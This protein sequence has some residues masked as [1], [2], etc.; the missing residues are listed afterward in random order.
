LNT[1]ELSNQYSK[2]P[3]F[4]DS[5]SAS[6]KKQKIL[7]RH[8]APWN[9]QKVQVLSE[10]MWSNKVHNLWNRESRILK[11]FCKMK[12]TNW[13]TWMNSKKPTESL[14]WKEIALSHSTNLRLISLNLS[15]VIVPHKQWRN[16]DQKKQRLQMLP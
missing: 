11:L 6:L 8:G 2:V 9:L 13:Q 1:R 14:S 15:K 12:W 7:E 10:Q 4:A 16:L 3:L 5:S